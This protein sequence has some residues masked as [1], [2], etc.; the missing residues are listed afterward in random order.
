MSHNELLL[1]KAK[2]FHKEAFHGGPVFIGGCGR[3]GTKWLAK[4]LRTCEDYEVTIEHPWV[5]PES[6]DMALQDHVPDYQVYAQVKRY[7]A[8]CAAAA[9]RRLIDK[10]HPNVWMYDPLKKYFP[11]A[12][13]IVIVR[14]VHQTINSMINHGAVVEK[15]KWWEKCCKSYN[16]ML[17]ITT[18][19]VDEYADYSF[20][21]KCILH[22]RAHVNVITSINPYDDVHFVDYQALVIWPDQVLAKIQKFL[23]NDKKITIPEELKADTDC[24]NKW[25]TELSK[26]A[27]QVIFEVTGLHRK[28]IPAP[29][30]K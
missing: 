15:F 20:V 29:I 14:S 21:K 23:G 13:F 25:R 7:Q 5:F 18:K 17:G 12:K 8:L 6:L 10:S 19:M 28:D 2:K 11:G 22:W 4:L 1:K 24:L 30:L 16:A 26:E 9:P 27:L 3:S